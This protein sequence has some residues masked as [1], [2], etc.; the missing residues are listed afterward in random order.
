MRVG[1][2]PAPNPGPSCITFSQLKAVDS[3]LA[4]IGPHTRNKRDAAPP[5]GR[6]P[7]GE[8]VKRDG[9]NRSGGRA[10]PEMEGKTSG[11]R[12]R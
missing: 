6:A 9:K 7:E 1:V 8:K 2:G 3:N 12:V 11:W 4:S 5:P 10:G